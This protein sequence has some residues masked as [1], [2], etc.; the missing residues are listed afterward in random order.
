M[1]ERVAVSREDETAAEREAR[2]GE[3]RER[4]AAD[5]EDET[6]AEREE[7]LGPMRHNAVARRDREA[8]TERE[9]RLLQDRLT[10]ATGRERESEAEKRRRLAGR[11]VTRV[12]NESAM[13]TKVCPHCSAL[14]FPSESDGMCCNSGK[15]V[16]PHL[17]A[18][19]EPLLSL[20]M[21]HG[22][23]GKH[24]RKNVRA[25]NSAFCMTSIGMKEAPVRDGKWMPCIRIQGSVHHLIGSLLPPPGEDPKFCQVYFHDREAHHRQSNF[26]DLKGPVLQGLQEMLQQQ[27]ARV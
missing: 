5:R 23:F 8:S 21:G 1:R 17:Q 25:Y 22:E 6:P 19:P 10:K 9:A 18:P 7:R 11:R 20:T 15:V 16:L 27:N 13:M 4:A 2:L 12:L 24:F 26:R 14:K 3:M